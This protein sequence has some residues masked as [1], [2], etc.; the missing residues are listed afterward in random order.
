MDMFAYHFIYDKPQEENY[1][2][3][4]VDRNG[5]GDIIINNEIFEYKW[6]YRLDVIIYEKE[7]YQKIFRNKTK[8]S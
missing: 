3:K 1:Q 7:L 2:I 5:E 8:L 6:D 4:V